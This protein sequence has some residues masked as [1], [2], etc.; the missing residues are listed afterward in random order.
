MRPFPLFRERTRARR[1]ELAGG[2]SFPGRRAPRRRCRSSMTLMLASAPRARVGPGRGGGP[3]RPIPSAS[4]APRGAAPR[5]CCRSPSSGGCRS[6][7]RSP[8]SERSTLRR[9]RPR[10][11]P[12][13]LR[14]PRRA[15]PGVV[16]PGAIGATSGDAA[17][18]SGVRG[19]SVSAGAIVP[20]AVPV[21]ILAAAR[22]GQ[23]VTGRRRTGPPAALAGLVAGLP[24][25]PAGPGDIARARADRDAGGARGSRPASGTSGRP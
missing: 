4:V 12:R 21:A 1:D 6:R 9:P 24:S 11:S 23:P 16:A 2:R 8:A 14:A 13:R 3:R 5:R 20:A 15:V 25:R 19:A 18:S 10:A 7:W 17:R 22:L